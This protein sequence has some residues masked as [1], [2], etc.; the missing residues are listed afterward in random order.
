VLWKT[1][2]GSSGRLVQ[3]CIAYFFFYVLTGV[4]VKYYQGKPPL[5]AMNGMQFLTYSTLGGTVLC[6]G[7]AISFGWWRLQS[8]QPVKFLGFSVPGEL[9]YI[10]PSGICTAVVIP[11]TTLMYSLKGIS[12]MVA[13]VIM[14]GS[15]IVISRSVDAIQ[16]KQG[17][18]KRK[19]YWLEDVAVVFAISAVAVVALFG[20]EQGK[21]SFIQSTAAMSILGSYVTAYFIRIYIMNFYKNTRAPGVKQDNK[22]FFALE[23]ISASGTLFLAAAIALAVTSDWEQLNQFQ[24]AVKDP[25]S[26]WVW[27][28]ALGGGSFGAVAFFSVFIFMFQGRTATFAGLVNRLTSLLAGTTATLISYFVFNDRAPKVEDWLSMGLILIAVGFLTLA[29]RR[30]S[31]ELATAKPA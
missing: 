2:P 31:A 29:E 16:I 19:V 13:M 10:V 3:L 1:A 23:Q 17:I 12:V 7:I 27:A 5:P 4:T 30:R 25:P 28:A 11:T 9:K 14:R 24:A 15:V 26:I 6:L 8:N 20:G 21:P 18:L 22:G